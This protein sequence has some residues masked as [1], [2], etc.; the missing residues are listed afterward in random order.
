MLKLLQF[1][2]IISSFVSAFTSL[3]QDSL[4]EWLT[5]GPP[6][7][8]VLI[9]IR[10]PSE[11]IEVIGTSKCRPYNL[12]WPEQFK[13]MCTSLSKEQHIILYCRSG[14]RANS[15]AAH[16]ETL[17]YTNV[18]NAGGVLTWNGPTLSKTDTTA[19]SL[20]PAPTLMASSGLVQTHTK[21]SK[22]SITETVSLQINLNNKHVLN[23]SPLFYTLKGQKIPFNALRLE[24]TAASLYITILNNSE[25]Y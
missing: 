20:L 2:F 5:S 9:D 13:Q 23:T 18:Y 21:A 25:E 6:F 3:P 22:R 8:I 15:A 24:K 19:S 4:K 1:L 16:L 10:S 17:G 7:D 12:T 11:L 14:N